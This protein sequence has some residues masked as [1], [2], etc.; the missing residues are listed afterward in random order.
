MAVGALP[1]LIVYI[2]KNTVISFKSLN[3][4]NRVPG[5]PATLAGA[6]HSHF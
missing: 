2:N 6:T 3:Q 4:Q 5:A 1:L